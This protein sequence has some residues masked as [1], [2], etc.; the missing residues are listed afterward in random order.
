[1]DEE[2]SLLPLHTPMGGGAYNAN[3]YSIYRY[4]FHVCIHLQFPRLSFSWLHFESGT[5]AR[6]KRFSQV[7]SVFDHFEFTERARPNTTI[8]EAKIVTLPN[9]KK[10]GK[11]QNRKQSEFYIF[12]FPFLPTIIFK[13]EATKCICLDETTTLDDFDPGQK[14]I[15]PGIPANFLPPAVI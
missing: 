14:G 3:Y 9:S 2:S 6:K 11:S 15:L 12:F 8:F 10:R 7:T 1:M 4:Y 5:K 13:R